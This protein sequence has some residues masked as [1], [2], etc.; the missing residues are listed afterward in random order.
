MQG[1]D[2][3]KS[4]NEP[5]QRS[6]THN[7]APSQAI[8]LSLLVEPQFEASQSSRVNMLNDNSSS[9]IS[10]SGSDFDDDGNEGHSSHS[11][12]DDEDRAR[13]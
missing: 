4:I 3:L 12:S 13:S 10:S 9:S 1:V 2:V 11:Y 8:T 7:I 5:A 6:L